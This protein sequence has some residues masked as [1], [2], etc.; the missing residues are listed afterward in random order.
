LAQ[1]LPFWLKLFAVK[2]ARHKSPTRQAQTALRSS[3]IQD[4]RRPEKPTKLAWLLDFFTK[5]AKSQIAEMGL[6][7]RTAHGI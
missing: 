6:R 1:E 7:Q 4:G 5:G 3:R 2:I